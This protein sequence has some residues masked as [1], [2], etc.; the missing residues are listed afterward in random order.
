MNNIYLPIENVNDYKCYEVRDKDTIRAYK[1][2]PQMNSTSPYD[3]FF[4]NSHYL[5]KSGSTTWNNYST[6]PTCLNSNSITNEVYY[7]NDLADILIIFSIISIV[8]FYIPYR[9]FSRFC[10]RFFQ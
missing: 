4:V 6:L 7:R 8:G 5:K 2:T 9:I 1:N 3:D 10:R